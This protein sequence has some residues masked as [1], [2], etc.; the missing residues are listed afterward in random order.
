MP[1]K[2]H[3]PGCPCC[4]CN[5]TIT[6]TIRGCGSLVLAGVSVNLTGPGGYDETEVT[7]SSGVATF[8]VTQNGTYSYTASKSRFVNATGTVTVSACN[9]PSFSATLSAASGYVCCSKCPD[10]IAE[11]LY[12]T[13]DQ[14]DVTLEWDGTQWVGYLAVDADVATCTSCVPDALCATTA[15]QV[16]VT[17]IVSCP[18]TTGGNFGLYMD[19]DGIERSSGVCPPDGI[20]YYFDTTCTGC[21]NVNVFSVGLGT[22][23]CGL[24]I[25]FS[26]TVANPPQWTLGGFNQGDFALD[27]P[28]TGTVTVSE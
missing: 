2:A 11:T 26:W 1:W 27:F 6:A 13:C 15:G 19:C 4:D 14:G 8:A 5:S 10:P 21:F 25:G 20:A 28:I 17:F 7:N 16:D 24:P 18:T 3:G 23:T 9:S 22:N 12:L